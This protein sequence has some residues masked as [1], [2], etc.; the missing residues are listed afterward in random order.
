MDTV[1]VA[2]GL[3][4]V[5]DSI[6]TYL[7]VEDELEELCRA[8]KRALSLISNIQ[9]DGTLVKDPVEKKRLMSYVDAWA[10]CQL[11]NGWRK[12]LDT[13]RYGGAHC[14]SVPC[15]LWI[16]E[17][18]LRLLVHDHEWFGDDHA[19]REDTGWYEKSQWREDECQFTQ[20]KI[21]C[22][23]T[24]PRL[25]LRMTELKQ[26]MVD[27]AL[28]KEVFRIDWIQKL[29]D[30]C[31]DRMCILLTYP[32]TQ[33]VNDISDYVYHNDEVEVVNSAFSWD[34]YHLYQ[35]CRR[36]IERHVELRAMDPSADALKLLEESH[37]SMGKWIV[38]MIMTAAGDDLNVIYR[39]YFI[40][41]T[42][43]PYEL[44]W[45]IRAHGK[46]PDQAPYKIMLY[47]RGLS[48]ANEVLAH[49]QGLVSNLMQL[50]DGRLQADS[51][52]AR[53]KKLAVDDQTLLT[54]CVMDYAVL[55]KWG[56]FKF[57]EW[58]INPE[59]IVED[60]NRMYPL[61]H[62]V[63]Y[64]TEFVVHEQW[65]THGIKDAICLWCYTIMDEFSATIFNPETKQGVACAEFIESI[66]KYKAKMATI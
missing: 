55:R 53:F 35:Y 23:K 59:Y 46:L 24:D 16:V 29:L 20:H 27:I 65:R 9:R 39:N 47:A 1:L 37:E 3:W 60:G 58:V 51:V 32:Y 40:H 30:A 42:L 31:R 15:A 13:I 62:K 43:R 54:Q 2:Q 48:E 33:D 26:T 25:L 21:H 4:K 57:D 44:E 6:N 64:T 19:F 17:S 8:M 66:L 5:L 14:M 49:G 7:G 45:Y 22:Y 36:T 12:K 61:L 41:A 50:E 56:G 63:P 52:M 18:K 10:E 11:D 28:M 34:M 38:N